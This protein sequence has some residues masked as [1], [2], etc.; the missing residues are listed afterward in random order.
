M[1]KIFRFYFIILTALS[2]TGIPVAVHNCA[3]GSAG[4][5]D[6]EMCEQTHE[7]E[8]PPC[9][10]EE[11]ESFAV[12]IKA[13][14]SCC[15]TKLAASPLQTESPLYGSVTLSCGE[16]ELKAFACEIIPGNLQ[17]ITAPASYLIDTS[18]PGKCPRDIPILT[19][20]LLI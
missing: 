4:K 3:T 2:F 12:K 20:S 8:I 11:I 9:C 10:L 5:M 13:D 16:K 7:K 6:C 19:S 18:P 1:L 14:K 17:A 15:E